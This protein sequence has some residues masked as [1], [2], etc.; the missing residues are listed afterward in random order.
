MR[1]LPIKQLL[2]ATVM[3]LFM[4]G[5]GYA[6][7]H[8]MP[9]QSTPGAGATLARAPATV[10]IRFDSA[11]EPLFSK[12]IV[13]NAQGAQV[14]QGT[15]GVDR[16]NPQVLFTRLAH[17]GKGSYHVYWNVAARDGHRTEGDYT[18]KVQ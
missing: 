10:S 7:A 5:S 8:A 12:L 11:L 2:S 3:T 14:S 1:K 16:A 13:K 17:V 4:L 15:G 6:L 9:E 18:F